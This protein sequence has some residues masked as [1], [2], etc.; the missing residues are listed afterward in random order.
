MA[1]HVMLV[2][3]GGKSVDKALSVAIAAGDGFA[4]VAAGG[5]VI[6]GPRIADAQRD[7][8]CRETSLN[9]MSK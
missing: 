8:P 4:L 6:D 2:H 9:E 5:D 7:A 1:A 3:H